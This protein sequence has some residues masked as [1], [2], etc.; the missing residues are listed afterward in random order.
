MK[1]AFPKV[2]IL[3]ANYNNGK[4]ITDC[5]S[6]VISQDYLNKEII[7]IDDRSTDNSIKILKK[8][9]NKITILTNNKKRK[10]GFIN[11][12]NVYNLGVKYSRGEL[13]FFLDSDDFFEKKKI[14]SI[15]KEFLK[16]PNKKILFDL[17]TILENSKKK[18]IK[19]R[20]KIIKTYW[21][22]IPPTSCITIQKKYFNEIFKNI[23][24]NNFDKIWM[25]FRIGIFAKYI[26]KEFHVIEK[27]LT[28]YRKTNNNVS[29][30]F[31]YLSRNWW[32]R[33]LQAFDYLIFF[34]KRN[35]INFKKNL[36]FYIT[37]IIN[38][39]IK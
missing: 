20:E 38:F 21:P 16:N 29:S 4:Y 7:V 15:V 14:M 17:P 35:K 22:Y 3:I 11:Q 19:L 8:F 34:F 33:R 32:K 24:F 2:S 5:I 13:I 36:D 1:K 28:I 25:D 6:S 31:N 27:N 23:Y 18:K 30:K 37:K 10:S 39:L 12:M 9:G 26:F